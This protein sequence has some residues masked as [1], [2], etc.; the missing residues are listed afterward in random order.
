[1]EPL[2]REIYRKKQ[3]IE[4]QDEGVKGDEKKAKYRLGFW[5]CFSSFHIR[6]PF[7]RWCRIRKYSL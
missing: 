5:V 7:Y 3:S 2:F 4:Y 1:M 6:E